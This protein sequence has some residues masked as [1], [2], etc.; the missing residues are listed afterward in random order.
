MITTIER[1][2][3]RHAATHPD[4]IA[5]ATPHEQLTY[6]AFNEAI[7]RRADAFTALDNKAQLFE[8]SQ[9]P[10][11]LINYFALHRAGVVAVPVSNSLGNDTRKALQQQL[12]QTCFPANS[13]DVL[14]T[15]GTTGQAKGVLISHEAIM[16][17]A[18]NLMTAQGY[19]ADTVFI[20]CGPINHLGSLSKLY[21]TFM[22][23]ATIYL[24]EGLND[25]NAFFNAFDYPSDKF[26]TFMVPAHLRML[27]HLAR[28]QLKQISHKLDFIETG[29]APMQVCDMEELCRLL[30]TTRLY[31]TYA[32]TETGIIATHNFN[33][34]QCWPGCVGRAMKHAS[35]S[36]TPQGT[37]AC[38]GPTLMTE[39]VG[40]AEATQKVKH[41]GQ[42]FT[43]DLGHIDAQGRLFIDGRHSE[44]I[45][46]GGYKVAPTDVE[47]AALA[48]P[49]VSDCI[50]IATPHPITD[51]ALKL[52]VVCKPGA[53]LDK[54]ALA[55]WLQTRLETYQV[56]MQYEEV[57]AIKRTFNGK[58]DRKAYRMKSFQE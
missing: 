55:Q 34:D 31:N 43:E 53:K 42:L 20:I 18:E 10:D 7:N 45:N 56:P 47:A 9:T 28:R 6:A 39:Y 24:L 22:Q 23:G 32:S 44:V 2:I 41:D 1:L 36:I 48:H 33:E 19:T 52:L 21:P 46:I 50:C 4:K 14:Y 58:L 13:A 40:D 51:T 16:A 27:I 12:E 8:S 15:T 54:R 49:G 25:L 17:N 30:P 38:A 26:A 35:F 29:A 37:I 3:A 11:F 57:T 5:I